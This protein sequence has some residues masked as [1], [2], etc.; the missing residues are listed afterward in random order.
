MALQ[1]LPILPALLQTAVLSLLSAAI[2]LS[3]SLTATLLAISQDG[4]IVRNPPTPE[5]QTAQSIHVLAFT[6]HGELLVNL[7]E[8]GFTMEQW[9]DVY[10]HAEKICC[11]T[12]ETD[13]DAMVDEGENAGMM[14]FVKTVME[15]KVQKDLAWRT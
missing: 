10:A 8:G 3:A 1:N 4:T 5:I 6:S 9:E 13:P 15:E 11:G 7:S 12:T 2:P 14:Q